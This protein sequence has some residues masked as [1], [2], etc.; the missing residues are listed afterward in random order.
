MRNAA[1]RIVDSNDRGRHGIGHESGHRL[2]RNLNPEVTA[3]SVSLL[4]GSDLDEEE[5]GERDRRIN[6]LDDKVECWIVVAKKS[7]PEQRLRLPHGLR[8]C[9]K[10]IPMSPVSNEVTINCRPARHAPSHR[11]NATSRSC[12]IAR[13]PPILSDVGLIAAKLSSP[14]VYL[15]DEPPRR[16]V[17]VQGP[18]AQ[19]ASAT[20]ASAPE[21]VLDIYSLSPSVGIVT[22]ARSDSSTPHSDACIVRIQA[23]LPLRL[24]TASDDVSGHPGRDPLL[25]RGKD[26]WETVDECDDVDHRRADPS[27]RFPELGVLG[28]EGSA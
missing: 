2:R 24:P 17:H 7:R 21:P 6:Q 13:S 18:S 9:Q 14:T 27:D 16:L 10:R 26:V 20:G 19:E 22:T 28:D 23:L 25:F 4:C 12:P 8:Q 5:R 3:L 11:W 1:P 15:T